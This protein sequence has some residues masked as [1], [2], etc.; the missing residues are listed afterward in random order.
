M[1]KETFIALLFILLLLAVIGIV[2]FAKYREKQQ[3][4]VYNGVNGA[5]RIDIL[6]IG[7]QTDYF[8]YSVSEDILYL[9]PL[10]R[11][12][13]DVENVSLEKNLLRHLRKPSGTRKVYIT[14]DYETPNKTGQFSFIALQD[15]GKILG[16]A[17]FGIYKL[18]V[19]A[20]L[21]TST[22]R[23]VALDVPSIT[24]QN[25][26]RTTAVIYLTLGEENRVYSRDE[27][28]IVEGKDTEGLLR[29]ATKFAYYL[30]GVF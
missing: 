13:Q 7:N 26:N 9:T 11:R 12:P 22:E 19:Q 30:L 4:F 29:S 21:T 27:C 8:V 15:I 23:S 25:V 1:K 20:A 16:R 10:R 5:Y 3:F 28:I 6:K 2:S 18:D 17:T 14:Q 24:C